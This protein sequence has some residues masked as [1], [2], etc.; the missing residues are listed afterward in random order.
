MCG[1]GMCQCA[2]GEN[3]SK[4]PARGHSKPYTLM[5]TVMVLGRCQ[6]F[7]II[8]QSIVIF[9]CGTESLS[10]G[11]PLSAERGALAVT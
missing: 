3:L 7:L 11:S 9:F 10:S 6:P 1:K 8:L 4:L 5:S 2:V